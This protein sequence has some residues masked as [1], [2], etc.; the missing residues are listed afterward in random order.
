MDSLEPFIDWLRPTRQPRTIDT[1]SQSIQAFVTWLQAFHPA[2]VTV[3][4]VTAWD[5]VQYR[6]A[7]QTAQPPRAATTINKML[8]ALAVWLAWGVATGQRVDNPLHTIRRIGMP[9]ETAPKGL[10]PS[11]QAQL[12]RWAQQ[13]RH[14]LRDTTIITLLLQTGLRISELCALTWG[15]L[16]IRERSGQVLVRHGKGNTTRTVPLSLTARRVLWTWAATTYQL[17]VPPFKAFSHAHAETLMAW[18]A[19]HRMLPVFISQKGGALRPRT[20]QEMVQQVAYHAQLPNV[21]PHSLRHTFAHMLLTQG[22]TLTEVAQLLGHASVATT[23]IYT[24]T[25]DAGLQQVI[26]RLTIE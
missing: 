24:K 13:T 22:A 1:Y 15:D 21:T 6:T 19:A 12:L 4:T 2:P 23:Q 10:S 9:A 3:A 7:L 20:I 8:A 11:E 5:V 18:I 14:P 17:P 26:E 16:Q 25:S